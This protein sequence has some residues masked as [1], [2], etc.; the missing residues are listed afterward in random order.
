MYVSDIEGNAISSIVVSTKGKGSQCKPTDGSGRTILI[1]QGEVNAGEE[2]DLVLPVDVK[3]NDGWEII[4]NYQPLIHAF[5][6]NPNAHTTLLLKRKSL[7]RAKEL[8]VSQQ[9][10]TGG[11]LNNTLASSG[12]MPGGIPTVTLKAAEEYQKLQSELINAYIQ[13]GHSEYNRNH[14]D[15][16]LTAYLKVLE[17]RQDS[18]EVLYYVALCL[19]RQKK[20]SDA[21]PYIEK[22]LEIRTGK[23]AS[24]DLALTYELYSIVLNALNRAKE[25]EKQKAL[26]SEV[27]SSLPK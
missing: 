10:S 26:A 17:K 3:E 8:S 9:T 5:N 20:Y 11:A 14:F 22:C 27:R 19:L 6:N 2:I 1:L 24:I 7:N 13:L 25:A 15:E 12:M 21:L 23:P 18:D 4:P 16:A